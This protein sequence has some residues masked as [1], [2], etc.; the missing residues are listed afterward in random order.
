[1][2][3]YEKMKHILRSW[4]SKVNQFWG[5]GCYIRSVLTLLLPSIVIGLLIVAVIMAITAGF[6]FLRCYYAQLIALTLALWAFI[7]W[8]DKRKADKIEIERKA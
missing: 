8:W 1:M 5:D 2:R 3:I 6:N 4:N 7:A